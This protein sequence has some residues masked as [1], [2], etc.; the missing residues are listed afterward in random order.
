MK[1]ALLPIFLAACGGSGGGDDGGPA[2]DA[3]PAAI[4]PLMVGVM[5]HVETQQA[6]MDPDA[7]APYLDRIRDE[8]LPVLTAHGARFTWEF[9]SE[10]LARIEETGDPILEELLAAGQGIGVHADK[11]YPPSTQEEFTD[12]LIALKTQFDATLDGIRHVSGICSEHD[13]V[14][15]AADA[16]FE[17]TTGTVAYCVMSLPRDQRPPEYADCMRPDLCHDPYPEAVEDRI[18]P[19]RMADGA[20]WLADDAAG[21]LVI[22]PASGG[23][24]C[25]AE[26]AGGSGPG[27]CMHTAADTPLFF[28]DLDAA[29]AAREP[30][31][32]NTYH[33]GWSYGAVLNATV[34]EDW[35]TQLD[36]YIA[37]GDVVWST[38][39]EQYDA[40]LAWEA[41]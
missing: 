14:T 25:A 19:W 10:I 26:E 8:F 4:T 13:W 12:E 16:G 23:L 29:L 11:G 17:F 40:Y 35:L 24:V 30:G 37:D 27:G 22:L 2:P 3:G 18:H 39:G 41:R 15:A 31:L 21:R 36:A 7:L 1:R 38:F 9:R 20:T 6:W 33:R 28:D 32:L 5:V 34:A